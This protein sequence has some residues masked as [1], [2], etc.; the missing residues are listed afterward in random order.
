MLDLT[1][2]DPRVANGYADLMPFG[3]VEDPPGTVTPAARNEPM[4][5]WGFAEV[6]EHALPLELPS[7]SGI[8]IPTVAGYTAL[9]LTAW[10]DRSVNGEYKDALDIAAALFWYANSTEVETR[11]YESEHGQDLLLREEYDLV[12]AAA[13]LLGEEVADVAG[14][15]RVSELAARWPTTRLDLL[16]QHMDV[17][18]TR[19][20]PSS[21]N[22]RQALVRAL[23]EGLWAK[24]RSAGQAPRR[25]RV[26]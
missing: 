10:L 4:S 13:R 25:M 3:A 20:W 1:K 26:A 24:A 2:C 15:T 22:R 9:K 21:M 16:Y 23:E 18:G 14:P 17:V 5:V 6:F 12:A 19:G 11:L 8:R 7:G